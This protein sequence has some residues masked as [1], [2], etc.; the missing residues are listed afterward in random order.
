[1]KR[2]ESPTLKVEVK[3]K[4]SSR[5]QFVVD[6]VCSVPSLNDR[7]DTPHPAS[8]SSRSTCWLL[9]QLR[10]LVNLTKALTFFSFRS[11]SPQR[12]RLTTTAQGDFAL[13]C[14][15]SF[16]YLINVEVMGI[17]APE[18]VRS[19]FD[20]KYDQGTSFRHRDCQINAHSRT[21]KSLRCIVANSVGVC[22]C[23]VTAQVLVKQHLELTLTI[24]VLTSTVSSVV[25][26][27]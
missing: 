15:C 18:G 21:G 11:Q 8:H 17:E 16:Q 9:G 25:P 12:S 1:M 7:S 27:G 24:P 19:S 20:G 2:I 22:V 5:V 13:P 23:A 26:N 3:G 10:T 14:H 6:I 4:K